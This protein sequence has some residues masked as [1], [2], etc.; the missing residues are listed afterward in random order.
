VGHKGSARIATLLNGVVAVCQIEVIGTAIAF[1]AAALSSVRCIFIFSR[2]YD[3]L[4][5]ARVSLRVTADEPSDIYHPTADIDLLRVILT[6][7]TDPVD[8]S[9]HALQRSSR[10]GLLVTVLLLIIASVLLVLIPNDCSP[11]WE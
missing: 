1:V 6:G 7:F 3:R 11:L 8:P 10:N 2:F 9:T 4:H 5:E